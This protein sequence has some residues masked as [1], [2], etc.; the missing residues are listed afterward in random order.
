ME[1][2]ELILKN[3]FAYQELLKLKNQYRDKKNEIY[4]KGVKTTEDE[5]FKNYILLIAELCG[6]S[7][8]SISPVFFVMMFGAYFYNDG[9]IEALVYL[10][11]FI[12]FVSV[13]IWGSSRGMRLGLLLT[14]KLVKLRILMLLY[15]V[16]PPEIK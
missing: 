2:S 3:G 9:I 7:M 11:I 15:R 13:D 16:S 14:I 6:G 10:V 12:F 5:S 1:I 8:M 4:G